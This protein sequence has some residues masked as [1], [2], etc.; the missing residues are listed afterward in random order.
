MLTVNSARRAEFPFGSESNLQARCLAILS[1]DATLVVQN[2]IQERLLDVNPAVVFDETQ[3]PEFV[4]EE[5]NPG[6]CCANHLRQRLLRY[7]GKFPLRLTLFSIV[8]E[9]QKSPR[10]PFLARVKE[11]IDQILLDSDTPRK[12]VLNEVIG[13]SPFRA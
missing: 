5:I 11:L 7:F 1:L 6:P 10:Q 13:E 3:F 9:Q 12:H 4:H 2:N 8:R